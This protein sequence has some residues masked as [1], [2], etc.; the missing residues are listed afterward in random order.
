MASVTGLI[1]V[2]SKHILEVDAVPSAVAG[3]AAPIASMAMYDDSVSGHL[4]LKVGSGDTEWKE[5]DFDTTDDWNLYGNVLSGGT[6]TTPDQLFGSL[7]D[8]DVKYIRNNIEI[9]RL[10]T[11]GVLIGLNAS[12]GGRLQVATAALGDDIVKQIGPNGGSG[13]QVIHVTRQYKV[14][15]TTATPATLADV[16]LPADCVSWIKMNA[17]A[18]QHGGSSGAVGDGAVYVRDVH[19]KCIASTAS[20]QKNQT[21]FTSEDFNQWDFGVAAS[22]ANV[23]YT[24]TGQANKN[25]AWFGHAEMMFAVN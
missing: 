21:S 17:V 12:L 3:T 2:N 23:R 7:N 18:R 11:A 1:T 9:M 10:A 4:Y 8:F 6:A 16:L 15:T 13:A 24:V 25:V 19:A 22:G 5:I 20:L 14:Q